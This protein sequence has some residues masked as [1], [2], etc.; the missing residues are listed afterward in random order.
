VERQIHDL[1]PVGQLEPAEGAV[2]ARYRGDVVEVDVRADP[3]EHAGAKVDLSSYRVVDQVIHPHR[4]RLQL[5]NR[6]NDLG[7]PLR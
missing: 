2:G 5:E 7:C 6:R 3:A 1:G 4:V